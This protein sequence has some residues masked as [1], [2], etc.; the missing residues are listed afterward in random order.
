M[1]DDEKPDEGLGYGQ[2]EDTIEDEETLSP[3][4]LEAGEDESD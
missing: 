3:D 4:E 1:S 2:G